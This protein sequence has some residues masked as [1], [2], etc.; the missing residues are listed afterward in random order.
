MF[1]RSISWVKRHPI[2]S[3]LIG[4]AG[5]FVLYGVLKPKP[6][7]FD[8]VTQAVDRGP[9]VR[10]VSASGKIRALNTIKVGAEVSGQITAVLVDFNSEV[11]KGQLL[12]QIDP[13]RLRARTQQ[14][15]AQVQLARA[16]EQ[17]ALAAIARA[18]A[19]AELQSREYERR[20][21]LAKDGFVS[22]SALDVVA[23]QASVARSS[24]KSAQA[25]L[26]TARAQ[27]AQAQ[28]ELESAQLDLK[29]ATIVAPIDGVVI[30]KLVE[31][32]NTVV[33]S[34]QTP[35]LFE[36]AADIT[37]MQVEASVD[38]ADIGQIRQSQK[39]QFTV[40]SYADETF[41]GEV[42]QI[43]K[44]AT[45]NQN[46]VSY[47]VILEVDNSSGKL[48]P[49][50]TANVDIITGEK[51]DVLRVPTGA[52]RFRP[53]KSAED[54]LDARAKA[55]KEARPAVEAPTKKE[56]PRLY[57]PT[58]DLYK[59]EPVEVSLGIEGEDYVEITGGNLKTG[60]KIIVRSRSLIKKADEDDAEDG[61]A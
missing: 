37:R 41:K 4:L 45:E 11:R 25:Q 56:L 23:T 21:G 33:A 36:I 5:L 18:S 46:V 17:A 58:T 49:G 24:I 60:D 57:K 30:N 59:P 12:A 29:R 27:I 9:V 31:P 54:L 50:M 14:A 35:N 1:E 42:K 10:Q 51:A 8:Y 20:R 2:W 39:V 53:R 55:D 38:E 26:S 32:G 13:T 44:A 6:P 48:L 40:D 16:N 47:L 52:L 22:K 7:T 34:F 15:Q 19:D 43:R 28:A 61:G 3:G